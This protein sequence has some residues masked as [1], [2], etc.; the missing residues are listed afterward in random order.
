MKTNRV[1]SLK[2]QLILKL[3]SC[4]QIL[5]LVVCLIPIRPI[6][7]VSQQAFL[8]KSDSSTG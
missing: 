7:F 5:K 4:F 8:V 2:R 1:F 6:E 3:T